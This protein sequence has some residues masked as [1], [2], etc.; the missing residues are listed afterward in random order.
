MV[1]FQ[2]RDTRRDGSTDDPDEPSPAEATE[3][4]PDG[5]DHEGVGFAVVTVGSGVT[6]DDDAGGDAAVEELTGAGEVVTRE[7]IGDRFD[8]VQQTVGA[9]VDRSDID[10]VV[11]IG[12]TGVGPDDVTV[13]AVE[14]LLDKTLPGVGESVRR[15]I[16]DERGTAAIR[17]R[18]TGGVIDGVPLFCLP[19]EPQLAGIATREVVVPEA[20][21][22]A[23]LAAG[24]GR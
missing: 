17:T 18:A 11:T 19:G 20:D 3:E 16:S 4:P 1:D 15:G 8:G 13:E 2:S 10:V 24:E 12:G 14:P 7:V 5:S 6:I 9:L 22:L 23:S 21:P